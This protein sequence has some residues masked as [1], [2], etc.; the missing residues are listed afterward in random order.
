[1]NIRV[2]L[3]LRAAELRGTEFTSSAKPMCSH[4]SATFLFEEI[5]LI[6]FQKYFGLLSM[7]VLNLYQIGGIPL[8]MLDRINDNVIPNAI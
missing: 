2:G 1:M 4:N 5:S 8:F 3:T 7:L 6:V